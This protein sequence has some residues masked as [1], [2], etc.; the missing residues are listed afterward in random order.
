M[1]MNCCIIYLNNL[2]VIKMFDPHDLLKICSNEEPTT[3]GGFSSSFFSGITPF[4][5]TNKEPKKPR[6]EVSID[7]LGARSQIGA[8]NHIGSTNFFPFFFGYGPEG[9]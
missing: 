9:N 1:N 5:I 2:I 4:F 3:S 7:A 8:R 6:C